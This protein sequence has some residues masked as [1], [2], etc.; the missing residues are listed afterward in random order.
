M[1]TGVKIH[2]FGP[3][4]SSSGGSVQKQEWRD[5]TSEAEQRDKSFAWGEIN[6]R[7]REMNEVLRQVE[8]A[9]CKDPN[10]LI[11]KTAPNAYNFDNERIHW[12]C[13]KGDI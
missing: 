13:I 9:A 10:N 2:K 5:P 6:R 3:K 4:P 12:G 7:A 11:D 1:A 8:C